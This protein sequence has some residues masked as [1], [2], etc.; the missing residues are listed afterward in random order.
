MQ[1]KKIFIASGAMFMIA[2]LYIAGLILYKKYNPIK[3]GILHS[4]SGHMAASERPVIDAAL[5]AIEEIN[6][7]GGLLGRVI[8][9]IIVDGASNSQIFA[10]QAELLITEKKVEVIFGCWTSASRK[11]VK[12]IVE[13]HNHILFYPLQYEGIETSPNIIYTGATPN[14]QIFPGILWCLKNLGK[15]FFI[16]GSDYVYPRMTAII[17]GDLLNSVKIRLVGEEYLPLDSR[18]VDSIVEKIVQVKPEVIINLF[19][20][21]T[22]KY[23]FKALRAAG[24]TSNDI[25]TISFSIG[26]NEVKRLGADLMVGDYVSSSYFQSVKTNENDKFVQAF[27]DRYGQDR[28]LSDPMEAAYFSVYLWCQT[29]KFTGSVHPVEVMAYVQNQSR[30]APEGI[31]AIDPFNHNTWKT[32]RI[33]KVNHEGQFDIMWASE[34]AVYPLPYAFRSRNEWEMILQKLYIEWGNA[35]SKE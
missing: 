6:A 24:I 11:E 22:N 35:W 3:V 15:R 5:L 19:N 10:Q 34:K 2:G 9:P 16:V 33:G 13:K 28:V 31:V 25:P 4:L 1:I 26:E 14:Q 29:V 21:E 30:V 18:D 27:K 20:G 7:S 17:V 8:E 12:N 32:C 23:F